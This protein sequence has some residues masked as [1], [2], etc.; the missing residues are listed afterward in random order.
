MESGSL[1]RVV[2][3]CRSRQL[4]LQAKCSLLESSC[5]LCSLFARS[6]LGRQLQ[7]PKPCQACTAEAAG[8]TAQQPHASSHATC[9]AASHRR[10]NHTRQAVLKRQA[11]QPPL[12]IPLQGLGGSMTPTSTLPICC[13]SGNHLQF[14]KCDA[15]Q[16]LASIGTSTA[17]SRRCTLRC[18]S[19][20]CQWSKCQLGIYNPQQA[21][22]A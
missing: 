8:T 2:A 18:A 17:M 22:Q 13:M 5:L 1:C 16:R 4:A 12:S 19:R 14:Q 7:A 10:P 3:R 15:A 9:Q 21:I 11:P 6:L 20:C